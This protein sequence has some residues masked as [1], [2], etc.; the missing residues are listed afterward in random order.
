MVD[1]NRAASV[2][3]HAHSSDDFSI[4]RLPLA[5]K[6]VSPGLTKNQFALFCLK[7]YV[8]PIP[9]LKDYPYTT[10]RDSDRYRI[11][12]EERFS[13]YDLTLQWNAETFSMNWLLVGR[14]CPSQ[15]WQ[16]MFQC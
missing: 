7:R 4:Q 13:D 6:T 9:G 2:N 16:V 11:P 15:V 12:F 3:P 14:S 1:S 10:G 8:G 5:E